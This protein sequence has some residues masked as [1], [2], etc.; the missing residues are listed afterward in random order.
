VMAF[1]EI[2][3]LMPFKEPD[4]KT[5][6][7]WTLFKV[8]SLPYFEHNLRKRFE[9]EDSELYNNDLIKL[10][11]RNIDLEYTPKRA[12]SVQKYYMR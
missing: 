1:H 3:N 6:I 2:E 5:R 12:I 7:F 4:N 8:Q 10:V 9:A 11:L